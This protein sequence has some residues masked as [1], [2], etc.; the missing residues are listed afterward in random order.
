MP[1]Q[2]EIN[3]ATDAYKAAFIVFL[4]NQKARIKEDAV[5]THVQ[6]EGMLVRALADW[7]APCKL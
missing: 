6:H 1:D 7:V 5:L 4:N 3:T 2:D